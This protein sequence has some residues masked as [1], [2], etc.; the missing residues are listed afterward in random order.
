MDKNV[1]RDIKQWRTGE[2][3]RLS[4]EDLTAGT[5]L[6]IENQKAVIRDFVDANPLEFSLVDTYID[7]GISGVTDDRPDFQRLIDD[8][9]TGLINCVIVKDTSRFTRSVTDTEYYINTLFPTHGVRFIALGSPTVDSFDDPESVEG[10]QFHFENYF[11]EYF[12]KM[13]SKKIRKVFDVKMK[14]GDFIGAY[15]P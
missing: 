13:T 1:K 11:N 6:S 3:L 2:Y 4:K 12:V 10:M 15:A 14:N 9:K 7:D 8:V 5:S